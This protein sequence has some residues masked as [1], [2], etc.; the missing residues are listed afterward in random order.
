LVGVL[1]V[2]GKGWSSY[3]ASPSQLEAIVTDYT[4]LLDPIQSVG[5]SGLLD[6]GTDITREVFIESLLHGLNEVE[7]QYWGGSIRLV[8]VEPD[9]MTGRKLSYGVG[10]EVFRWGSRSSL[11]DVRVPYAWD[12]DPYYEDT[13]WV[14]YGPYEYS[15]TELKHNFALDESIAV[16]Y[17]SIFA[18]FASGWLLVWALGFVLRR[19]GVRS[20][21]S[22]KRLAIGV[23]ILL[24]GI[25]VFSAVLPNDLRFTFVNDPPV[26][27]SEWIEY[28]TL[29]GI[30]EQAKFKPDQAVQLWALLNS[31]TP[32][33]E[34][35]DL[36]VGIQYDLGRGFDVRHWSIGIGYHIELLSGT[37]RWMS[38]PDEGANTAAVEFPSEF[39]RGLSVDFVDRRY[40][41]FGWQSDLYERSVDIAPTSVLSVLAVVIWVWMALRWIAL[42]IVKQRQ[43]RR[44]RQDLCIFCAYPLSDEGK[45]A[46]SLGI[47]S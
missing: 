2:T 21:H 46:R 31:I 33:T 32:K 16:N 26:K 7:K 1:T 18:I 36:I 6:Q 20:L 34:D 23:G 15:R 24:L 17:V 43:R 37:T 22:P 27:T 38:N 11:L 45:K 39:D 35:G 3:G 13:V 41:T 42:L 14:S 4:A 25:V 30:V 5:Y 19:F 40:F 44:A 9:G 47:G 12:R 28:D 8:G 10:E 29:I